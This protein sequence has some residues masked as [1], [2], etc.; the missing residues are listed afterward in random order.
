MNQILSAAADLVIGQR[1][2]CI[3]ARGI[4][5]DRVAS[6]LGQPVALAVKAAPRASAAWP[7]PLSAADQAAKA[8]E[9][10]RQQRAD[11]LNGPRALL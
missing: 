5:Q 4:Q 6:R 11:I 1:V 2:Y 10:R 7:F 9:H 8:V 3:A